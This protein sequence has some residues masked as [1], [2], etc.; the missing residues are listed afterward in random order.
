MSEATLAAPL[1]LEA[2]L[3]WES[4]Q[5][6]RFERLDGRVR[7]VPARSAAHERIALN[8]YLGLRARL[9]TKSRRDVHL[10]PLKVIARKVG[11]VLYPDVLVRCG[12][13]LQRESSAEDP[14]VVFMVAAGSISDTGLDRQVRAYQSI[15]SMRSIVQ[16][17]EGRLQLS[18]VRRS[19]EG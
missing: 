4:R 10:A 11:A 18:L 15:P 1:E 3:A 9:R 17:T 7:P 12:P 6:E 5:P 19:R 13:L 14:V 2:F 8:L 16:V